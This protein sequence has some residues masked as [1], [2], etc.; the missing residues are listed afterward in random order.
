MPSAN[1][2]HP[3]AAHVYHDDSAQKPVITNV[4]P[5]AGAEMTLGSDNNGARNGKADRLRGGCIPCPVCPVIFHVYLR[6]R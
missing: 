6:P 2:A 1:V 5:R 3:P 4:Q